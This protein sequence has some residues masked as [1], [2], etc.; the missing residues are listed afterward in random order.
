MIRRSWIAGHDGLERH[1]VVRI[2][3][4]DKDFALFGAT[5]SEYSQASE[6]SL[7]PLAGQTE[8]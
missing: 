7:A 6:R 1:K 5:P 4:A 8:V 3:I 2:V